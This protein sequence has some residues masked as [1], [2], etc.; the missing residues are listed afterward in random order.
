MNI[1][2]IIGALVIVGVVAL[3]STL[4]AL[5]TTAPDA[6]IAASFYPIAF[7]TE[8]IAGSAVPVFSV[9][10]FDTE[11]HD[12]ELTPEMAL[13]LSTSPLFIH[14]GAHLEPWAN[15]II[16]ARNA[17]ELPS[18]TL[19][20]EENALLGEDIPADE[21]GDAGSEFDPHFWL[22]P[23]RAVGATGQIALVLANLY[24]AHTATFV[25]NSA[26]LTSELTRIDTEYRKGLA[27][28]ASRIIVTDHDA[29]GYLAHDYNLTVYAIRGISPDEE[30]SSATLA[31]ITEIVRANGVKTIFTEELV[32][33]DIAE[34]IARETG[35][36]VSLL[37]T[38]EGL[39]EDDIAAG[40][41]YL[42]K[43]RGNLKTLTSSLECE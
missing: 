15:A 19:L 21:P 30:P 8:Q 33:P 13:R 26:A 10:P 31:N 32:A 12:Y 22:S 16:T 37:S 23:K 3:G 1:K 36:T 35:A 43:L 18:L 6:A 40:N 9:T 41:D 14:T 25:A 29:F 28:C 2:Y 38:I 5:R 20:T 27:T 7:L 4:T 17:Q 11:P 39:T 24:P 42:S 34:T